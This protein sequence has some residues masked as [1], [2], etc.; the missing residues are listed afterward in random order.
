MSNNRIHYPIQQVAFRKPGS[1]AATDFREAHGVQSVSTTTTFNLEQAFE[2]GQLAIYENIEGIP[3]V[4]VSLTKLLDG[5]IPLYLLA[6][7]SDADGNALTNPDLAARAVAETVMQLGIWPETD[8]AVNASPA[9]YVEMSGL[10]VSSVSYNFP[11]EDNFSEDVTLVGNNRI[12]DTYSDA[13]CTAPWALVEATGSPNFADN[14]DAPIGSGGINRRENMLFATT[15]GQADNA[16]YTRLPSEIFGVAANGVK[17]GLVHVS[18]IT[19]ST[20]FGRENLFE[21]GARSPYAKNVTFPTEVTC[22]FEVTSVSGDAVNA[23]DDCNNAGTCTVADNLTN[24]TIRIST[25][26]GTRI[27]LGTKNKLSSVSYGG[28]DAN[29]GNVS[30]TYSY[31]TFNDFTVLHETDDFNVSGSSWWAARSGYLGASTQGI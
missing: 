4:E 12:W 27:Y 6:T 2:L 17:S 1:S 29:G 11:L 26:E 20:D 3:D 25:C 31:T 7:A 22:D 23:I 10:V 15:A 13:S 19:V 28:G 9:T 24:N 30:V 8:Q 18:S 21:L 5:Y 16:D 14:L